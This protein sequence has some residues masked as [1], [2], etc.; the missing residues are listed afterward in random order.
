MCHMLLTASEELSS[1]SVGSSMYV[2]PFVEPSD[3]KRRALHKPN[4]ILRKSSIFF[5]CTNSK[6]FPISC[7]TFS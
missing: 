3:H 2:E 7:T 5:S 6:R 1:S 4:I